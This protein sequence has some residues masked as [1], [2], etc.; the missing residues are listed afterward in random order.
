M[1]VDGDMSW[2]A[3]DYLVTVPAKSGDLYFSVET[4]YLNMIP[5]VC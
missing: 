1:D 3:N 5:F 4:Y 2:S